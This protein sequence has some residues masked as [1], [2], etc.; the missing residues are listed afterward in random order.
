VLL[1]GV[2][3]QNSPISVRIDIN[4]TTTNSQVLNLVALFDAIIELDVANKQVQILQ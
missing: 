4:T 1:S 3:S 2:S